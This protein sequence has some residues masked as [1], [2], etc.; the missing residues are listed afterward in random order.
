MDNII[1]FEQILENA[2]NKRKQMAV[3]L[4]KLEK[5]GYLSEEH[6]AHA[7]K[8]MTLEQLKYILS[9]IK[10]LLRCDLTQYK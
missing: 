10:L 2:S 7:L 8:F 1:Y 6:I 4:D 3:A 5:S 9:S